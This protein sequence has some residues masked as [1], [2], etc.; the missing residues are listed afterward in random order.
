MIDIAIALIILQE[1]MLHKA[2]KKWEL[3]Y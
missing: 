2:A 3:P 1:Y